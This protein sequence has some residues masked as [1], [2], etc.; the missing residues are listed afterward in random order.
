[1]K[2]SIE[3]YNNG[4][5]GALAI[6]LTE[7]KEALTLR[8]DSEARGDVLEAQLQEMEASLPTKEIAIR[9]QQESLT[10]RIQELEQQKEDLSG[11]LDKHNVEFITLRSDSETRGGKLEAQ[12]QD[13]EESLRSKESAR[14]QLEENL[15]SKIQEVEHQ[16]T[17]KEKLSSLLENHNSEIAILRSETGAK[18]GL[19]EAQLQD[20]EES[21]RSKESARKQLEENLTSKIQEMQHQLTEKEDLL[22]EAS[23]EIMNFRAEAEAIVL[24]LQAQL[25]GNGAHLDT[26]EA[27][28]ID[29]TSRVAPLDG[30]PEG[31]NTLRDNMVVSLNLLEKKPVEN[32][33]YPTELGEEQNLKSM[34]A[35]IEKLRQS[36][37]QGVQAIK[38]GMGLPM[39]KYE[40]LL[41]IMLSFLCYVK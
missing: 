37:T 41:L 15:T 24:R 2:V 3:G 1:M 4:S 39:R 35:E 11:L 40:N 12:L 31:F 21:L 9:Q 34:A 26:R 22:E 17:E 13:R 33:V 32:D 10:A 29:H 30:L 19:L 16:L 25:Q 8:S 5:I 18:V 28:L 23:Q 27:E 14:K 20:R 38:L 6:Y 36:K 7:L